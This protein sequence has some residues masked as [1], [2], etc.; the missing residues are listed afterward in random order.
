MK[1]KNAGNPKIRNRQILL[2]K[3]IWVALRPSMSI[4]LSTLWAEN[5]H[6]C[7]HAGTPSSTST[8]TKALSLRKCTPTAPHANNSPRPM[9]LVFAPDIASVLPFYP[10]CVDV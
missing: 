1:R 3:H 9:R 2:Y 7:R 8:G 6:Q 10:T 4:P 5:C